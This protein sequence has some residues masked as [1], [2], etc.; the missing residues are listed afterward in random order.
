MTKSEKFFYDQDSNQRNEEAR[1]TCAVSLAK[2]ERYALDENWRF[3][4]SEDDVPCQHEPRCMG[5]PEYCQLWDEN[6]N[7]LGSLSGICGAT[8][9]YRRL[10]QAELAQEA[11][12]LAEAMGR[13]V[14]APSL[15]AAKELWRR[16]E[17]AV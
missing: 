9:N 7:I 1:V 13:V 14:L 4:W 12:H 10:V 5:T 16:R 15:E 2:A 3:E 17:E 6:D 11:M 8:H